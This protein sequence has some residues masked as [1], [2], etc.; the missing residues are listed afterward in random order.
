MFRT[1]QFVSDQVILREQTLSSNKNLNIPEED[2][3]SPIKHSSISTEAQLCAC[4]ID[5][6]RKYLVG[7]GNADAHRLQ[8]D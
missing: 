5:T 7:L 1:D 8:Q 6:H 2:P 4:W 3:S